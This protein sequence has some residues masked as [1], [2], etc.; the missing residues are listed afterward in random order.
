MKR[1]LISYLCVLLNVFAYSQATFI[2]KI[3]NS[4][5]GSGI[6]VVPSSD[7][8]WCIISKDS[9]KISKFNSCG[10]P[11]WSYQYQL[12]NETSSLSDFTQ[13]QDGGFI[14][15][16]RSL[17]VSG[18]GFTLTKIN[19][20]GII[21][22]SN[23]YSQIDYDYYPYTVN[24]D[25]QGN[26][27]VFANST[28]VSTNDVN[29]LICKINPAGAMINSQFYNYG[30]T[31]G[32]SIASSDGGVLFRTGST[33]IKLTTNLA[34]QWV[35]RI[36]A[37]TYN[38]F[39]PIEVSNGYVLSGYSNG[40][41]LI[42]Y[43]KVDLNGN[44]LWGGSKQTNI[45]GTPKYLKKR[46]NGN[47][48]SVFTDFQNGNSY[49][50][51]IEFNQEMDFIS[52]ST[53]SNTTLIG[54]DLCFLTNGTPVVAGLE[55]SNV[56]FAKLNQAYKS[57]CDIDIN[58]IQISLTPITAELTTAIA[59]N[60]TVVVNSSDYSSNPISINS[61]TICTV[62]KILDLG[63]DT[64]L[65]DG[66]VITLQ[67]Q[68]S[69]S[70]DHYVWSNGSN[71]SSITVSEP[72]RYWL[73]VYDDCDVNRSNDTIWIELL[74]AIKADLGEDVLLCEEESQIFIKPDCD[75][76]QFVWSTGET[77][78]SIVV[79]EKG[80][81]WLEIL[82]ANGCSS[83]DTVSVDFGKCNC[84]FYVPN[85]FSPNNDGLNDVFSTKFDCDISEFSML[86][87][88]RWGELIYSTTNP[89][90]AW[91]AKINQKSVPTDIYNYRIIYTPTYL[92]ENT[93]PVLLNGLITV[94]N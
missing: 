91:N 54:T 2:K 86:I 7:L 23:S 94:L 56:F 55:G 45:V 60:H 4:N 30:G 79:N 9:L 10:D 8:G 82:N 90:Q 89:L 12:P 17:S 21:T 47:L 73:L 34:V 63:N 59:S 50:S 27:V 76:C 20:A 44:L 49:T 87:Y 53:F 42:S 31:W 19:A 77:T 32:G 71:A 48:A 51:I 11:D 36:F 35:A 57:G 46:A 29:N 24:Q 85:A 80:I 83:S 43:Y 93:T 16:S 92:G 74:P 18:H 78:D 22:W 81:Y 41:Q 33:L 64:V 68:T 6:R 69:D 70:F 25:I 28:Q 37:G 65:C 1:L 67:N 66:A 72:G 52:Q 40:G 15:L 88:N 26:Y 58:P 5:F 39:A 62:P 14:W 61:S 3:D 13:T 84:D 38:Y 75:N